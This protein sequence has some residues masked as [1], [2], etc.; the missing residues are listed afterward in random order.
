M[1]SRLLSWSQPAEAGGAPVAIAAAALFL[2]AFM[3]LHVGFLGRS[4]VD[5]SQI[6]ARYGNAIASG[7]VPYRDFGLEYPPGALPVFALPALG[8]G[9]QMGDTRYRHRFEPLMALCGAAMVGFMAIA[10]HSLGASRR[11]SLAALGFA[12]VFPLL[13]GSVVLTR[14]D[15]WA[16]A[17]TAAAAAALLADR[18]R[19][20]LG[21]LA[22]AFA[23][24]VYPAVLLPLA[25]AYVWRR[26]GRRETFVAGLW[27]A[28]VAA[29]AFVPFL[30]LAPG[31]VWAS[32]VRQTTRPLQIESLGASILLYAHQLFGS[33]ITMRS[34]HGSQNL[35]GP[36]ANA[37][38]A[39]QTVVEVAALLAVW[40]VFARGPAE[41]ERL[42]RFG[43]AAVCAFVA[44]G[45]VLSP[46]FLIW[47]VPLVPLVR[48][49]RGLAASA[50]LGAAML[51]T[52]VWF[53]YRYWRL[54]LQFDPVASYLVLPRDLLLAALF[55]VLAWPRARRAAPRSA[56]PAP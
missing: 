39:V 38:A 49:R 6:Y 33:G 9:G 45:K 24:K 42:V 40:V 48:G 15:L 29:L 44:F 18:P 50:L 41:K 34:S 11:R 17:L 3:L 32:V 20:G 53:P 12:A 25:L 55:A 56:A 5:D 16:A 36:G 47:L 8:G 30:A 52:H 23:A 1:S 46:Q 21:L 54:A 22:A 35:V 27:F 4:Q 7:K 14:F 28:A 31:G 43:A 2:A 26:R 37:I 10:L 51:L 13:L 19:L